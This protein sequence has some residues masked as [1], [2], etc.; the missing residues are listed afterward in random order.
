MEK[1]YLVKGHVQG[2]GYRQFVKQTASQLQINGWVRNLKN[3][4]VEVLAFTDEPTHNKLF[5]ALL[6]GPERSRVEE[7][8]QKQISIQNSQPDGF[9]ILE[10]REKPCYEL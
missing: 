1:Y 9:E 3:N 7:V 10:T 6:K 4:D 5:K 2:V 8:L